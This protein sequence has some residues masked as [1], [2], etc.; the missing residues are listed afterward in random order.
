MPATRDHLERHLRADEPRQALGPAAPRQDADQ[1]LGQPDLGAG[2]GDPVVRGERQFEPAAQGI[3]VDRGDDRLLARVEDLVRPPSRHRRR[4]VGAE[5]A[6]VGAGD[7]AAPGADQHHRPDQRVGVAALDILD[8]AFGHP[9]RQG[10]DRRVVDRD[11]ADPVHI[12]EAHQS[13]FRHVAS[14]P[15]LPSPVRL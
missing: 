9:G 14:L 6:D 7:K 8:D 2:N 3:A 12:L 13:A 11:D 15:F 1:D 5:S 4:P 10:V